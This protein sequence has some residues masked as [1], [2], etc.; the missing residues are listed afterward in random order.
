ME[1]ETVTIRDDAPLPDGTW[2]AVDAWGRLVIVE[3]ARD[4][5]HMVTPR[6]GQSVRG[7]RS[8]SGTIIDA[9]L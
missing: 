6:R 7:V 1:Q 8:G 9:G 4:G 2:A 3:M 5:H